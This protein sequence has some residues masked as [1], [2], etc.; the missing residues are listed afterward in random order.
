MIRILLLG[1]QEIRAMVREELTAL[2]VRHDF[3]DYGLTEAATGEEAAKAAPAGSFLDLFIGDTSLG[4]CIGFM[5]ALRKT[6]GETMIIPVADSGIPPTDYVCP[7]IMPFALIWK[8]PIGESI[9]GTL[10]SALARYGKD[11]AADAGDEQCFLLETRQEVRRIPYEHICYF[12]ARDK[13]LFLR[14]PG[15]EFGFAG[16]LGAL[17]KTVPTYFCRAYKSYLVNV[18]MV[19]SVDR[20]NSLAVLE[21]GLTVPISRSC[22][23]QFLEAVYEYIR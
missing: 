18:K 1:K 4:D 12:E 15:E 8:P 11:A 6:H 9:R 21:D 17:E 16:V 13:K 14:L 7:E 5:K 20:V 2:S 3:L 22:R 10:W 23:K 19:R